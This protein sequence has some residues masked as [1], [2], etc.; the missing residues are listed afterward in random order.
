MA[1]QKAQLWLR[2]ANNQEIYDWLKPVLSQLGSSYRLRFH[3][4][5]N[6]KPLE[7]P[8]QSAYYWGAFYYT[9]I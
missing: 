2:E 6:N 5:A 8:Y 3:Q 7:K 1:L 9:G 4:N